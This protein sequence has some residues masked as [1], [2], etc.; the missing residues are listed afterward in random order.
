MHINQV[1]DYTFDYEK[2]GVK[3]DLLIQICCMSYAGGFFIW[4]PGDYVN[5]ILI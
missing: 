2:A 4:Q 5:N 1:L 3:V